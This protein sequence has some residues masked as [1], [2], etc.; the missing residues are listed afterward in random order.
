MPCPWLGLGRL[1]SHNNKKK[2]IIVK[3][4]ERRHDYNKKI[5][6]K[7]VFLGPKIC[8]HQDSPV[9]A[10]LVVAMRRGSVLALLVR[11]NSQEEKLAAAP[12]ARPSPSRRPP[13]HHRPH[14]LPAQVPTGPATAAMVGEGVSTHKRWRQT[15]TM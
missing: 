2:H 12:S 13:A 10:A 6:N 7:F 14:F 5:R 1:G 9:H 8:T 15:A 11:K 3:S 4:K